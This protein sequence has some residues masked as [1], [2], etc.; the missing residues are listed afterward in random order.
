MYPPQGVA[1]PLV[2]Y[3]LVVGAYLLGTFPTAV[4]VAGSRGHDVTAV[5]SGNPGAT[6]V[7]RVAGARAGLVVFLGDLL[8]GAIATGAGLFAG[9]VLEL[10][11]RPRALALACGIAA[12]LGHCFPAPRR[13]R[14]GKGVATAGG[15]VFVV[16]PL[17]GL[18]GA[19]LWLLIAKVAGKA[20]L[21]S[22]A[23]AAMIPVALVVLGR[24]RTD[25]AGIG[26]LALVILA[27]HGENI[28]R[29]LRGEEHALREEPA[30]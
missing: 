12:V 22:L 2:V 15:V 23:V 9:E 25:L 5:G 10:D 8:K 13:F 27:R 7:Y 4:L 21:A 11:M 29:L 17:V 14:G 18:A 28:S 1:C 16:E 3:A 19:V 24:S 6:N 30:G 26:I 20:S